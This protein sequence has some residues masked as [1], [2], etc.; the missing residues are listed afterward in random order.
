[1]CLSPGQFAL[2]SPDS[3]SSQPKR[4]PR[5]ELGGWSGGDRP[6]VRGTR[7]SRPRADPYAQGDFVSTSAFAR[8]NRLAQRQQWAQPRQ[9]DRGTKFLDADAEELMRCYTAADKVAD[10]D[11][12]DVTSSQLAVDREIE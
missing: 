6:A 8:L 10:P 3:K 4:S 5:R 12:D 7:M 9:T 11:L 1:M 2:R